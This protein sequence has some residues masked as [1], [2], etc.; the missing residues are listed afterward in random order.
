MC[1]N[2]SRSLQTSKRC[3]SQLCSQSILPAFHLQ[4]TRD[5]FLA[6]SGEPT[7]SGLDPQYSCVIVHVSSPSLMCRSC[8]FEVSFISALKYTNATL[9]VMRCRCAVGQIV[10]YK[11]PPY[12]Y[13]CYSAV[14][15]H[16]SLILKCLFQ[17]SIDFSRSAASDN[18]HAEI[19]PQ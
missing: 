2:C 7:L 12:T 9:W 8:S 15:H 5:R 16:F 18:C 11:P 13:I 19:T 14:H 6:G 1:T 17:R 3:I 4:G 10:D